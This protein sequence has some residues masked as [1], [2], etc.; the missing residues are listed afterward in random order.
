M[1]LRNTDHSTVQRTIV[2]FF[3]R[4]ERELSEIEFLLKLINQKNKDKSILVITKK[5]DLINRGLDVFME[6][7]K[8][9]LSQT[10]K[11]EIQLLKRYVNVLKT[12]LAS[13]SIPELLAILH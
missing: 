2:N 10:K 8:E 9:N 6:D 7:E 1:D 3:N 11:A 12:N 13:R 4:F 5:L